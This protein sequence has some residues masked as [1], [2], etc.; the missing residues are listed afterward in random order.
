MVMEF[1]YP[2]P[3]CGEEDTR[4]AVLALVHYTYFGPLLMVIV[5]ILIL[6]ISHLTTPQ[7]EEEVR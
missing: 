6:A 3:N 7:R 1:V 2:A 5:T 4:P